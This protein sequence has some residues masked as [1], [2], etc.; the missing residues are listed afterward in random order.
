[1][2]MDVELMDDM[3][4]I[5]FP[6]CLDWDRINHNHFF[7]LISAYCIHP[8]VGLRPQSTIPYGTVDGADTIHLGIISVHDAIV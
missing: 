6:P 3:V 4:Q 7:Y 5:S 1:M 2:S 8:G